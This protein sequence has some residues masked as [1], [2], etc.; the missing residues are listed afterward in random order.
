MPA[1]RYPR[2]YKSFADSGA[3][4]N[5]NGD[6][7]SAVTGFTDDTATIQAFIDAQPST[8]CDLFLDRWY[9]VPG[10]LTRWKSNI[11]IVGS[12]SGG[13]RGNPA[14]LTGGGS[15]IPST[16]ITIQGALIGSPLAYGSTFAAGTQTFPVVNT[17]APGDVLMLWNYPTDPG[18]TDAYTQP[19]GASAPRL[20]NYSGSGALGTPGGGQVL[21]PNNLRQTRRRELG[22]VLAAVNS[23]GTA[24]FSL[25]SPTA[26]GYNSTTQLQFQK[27]APVRRAVLESVNLIDIGVNADLTD[28]FQVRG[29]SQYRSTISM[30]RSLSGQATGI[31]LDAELTDTCI[32]IGASSRFCT[33]SGNARGGFDPG[34]DNAL[35]RVDQAS[36]FSLDFNLN[37]H[38][39]FLYGCLIDTNY[40]EA[41]DGFS[42][43]PTLVGRIDLISAANNII[44][45]CT[46]DPFAAD[47]SH[48][49][50]RVL[51]G[52]TITPP[53]VYLK[54]VRDSSI[55]AQVANSGF[56]F[57]G[58]TRIIITGQNNGNFPSNLSDPRN[59]GGTARSNTSI[60][61]ASYTTLY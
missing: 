25:H 39:S 55:H 41:P 4:G 13:F 30:G 31:D 1:N 52:D 43:V 51:T 58:N 57:D 23:G 14:Y 20:Y 22:I 54:G 38:S 53:S 9:Y 18:G 48:I 11:R 21:H 6:P 49:D 33:A 27:V 37:G 24:G 3:V 34:F 46:C 10:G 35:I 47:I 59:P 44:L 17:W 32:N 19:G 26:Y 16:V 8:G 61:T 40:L 7:A 29:G 45:F 5:A 60:K 42:D 28:R 50:A 36:N 12:N 15:L 56:R 2:Y